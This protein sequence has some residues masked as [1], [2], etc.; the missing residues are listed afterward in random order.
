MGCDQKTVVNT[1]VIMHS[2]LRSYIPAIAKES[3]DWIDELF[4]G[5]F[6][7]QN[8]KNMTSPVTVLGHSPGYLDLAKNFNTRVFEIQTKGGDLCPFV[9]IVKLNI[10]KDL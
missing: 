6:I 9:P 8:L 3:A 5:A 1:M 10:R 2:I 7:I 4:K